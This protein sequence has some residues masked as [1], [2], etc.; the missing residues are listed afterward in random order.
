MFDINTYRKEATL[1]DGTKILLRAM[2]A[3]DQD[4]LYDFFKAV[5]REDSRCL[6]DAVPRKLLVEKWTKSL[7]NTKTLSL[8]TIMA[9]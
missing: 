9:E 3:E 1:K 5:L 7:D 4:A 8:G 2:V 6:G